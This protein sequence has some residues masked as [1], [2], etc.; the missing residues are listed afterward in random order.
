MTSGS[1]GLANHLY[2]HTADAGIAGSEA[3]LGPD[4]SIQPTGVSDL[5]LP[6]MILGDPDP[7]GR[8]L[9]LGATGRSKKFGALNTLARFSIV[10]ISLY[11]PCRLLPRCHSFLFLILSSVSSRPVSSWKE[12]RVLGESGLRRTQGLS[13]SCC[14]LRP[15][16]LRDY[17]ETGAKFLCQEEYLDVLTR[18]LY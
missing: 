11:A 9:F 12:P 6:T 16:A 4:L 14:F 13:G 17:A 3:G 7:K 18:F 5:A 15:S 10:L 1:W 2:K 8:L